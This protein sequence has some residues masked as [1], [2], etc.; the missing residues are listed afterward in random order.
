[1]SAAAQV[2]FVSAFIVA[3]VGLLTYTVKWLR[4]FAR[5]LADQLGLNHPR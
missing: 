3:G 5:H 2:L 1:M 4:V